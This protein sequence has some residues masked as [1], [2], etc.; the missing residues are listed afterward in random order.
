[1]RDEMVGVTTWDAAT[2]CGMMAGAVVGDAWGRPFEGREPPLVVERPARAF[3]SDDTEL[4]LA[5]CRAVD[6]GG[7]VP[8]PERVAEELLRAYRDGVVSGVGASTLTALRSL[9]QGDHWAVA[10]HAGEYAAGNGAAMRVAPLAPFLDVDDT[11]GRQRLRDI[12]R[13]THKNDE[14]YAGALALVAA[15]QGAQRGMWGQQLVAHVVEVT[16]D[17]QTRDALRGVALGPPSSLSSQLGT[18]GFSAE[19]VPFAIACAAFVDEK[20]DLAAGLIDVIA[21]G[22]DADTNA[23]MFGSI[24]GV[25]RGA[26]ST[27]PLLSSVRSGDHARHVYASRSLLRLLR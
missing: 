20:V 8:T 1:M 2:F 24:V 6:A 26:V 16:C 22:G 18:S 10:G 23:S 5:T 7:G 25:R 3:T 9:A 12:C 19:S 11:S 15:L 21:C 17:S 27:E 13:I 14:A 4:L